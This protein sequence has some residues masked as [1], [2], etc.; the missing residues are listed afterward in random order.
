MMWANCLAT[1]I[2]MMVFRSG[3]P[4]G[5]LLM[6]LLATSI[7]LSDK[8]VKGDMEL[9]DWAEDIHTN[10][11][12]EYF[13]SEDGHAYNMAS[14]NVS[15]PRRILQTSV[16]LP[17]SLAQLSTLLSILVNIISTELSQIHL[18]LFTNLHLPRKERPITSHCWR[19]YLPKKMLVVRA[20]F[21]TGSL[22]TVKMR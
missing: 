2:G 19:H 1:T 21:L 17:C 6:R 12:P 18:Q 10:T 5:T 7:R 22:D 20:P 9:Q 14:Q 13:G 3:K 15:P 11:F 8:E 16:L 4:L